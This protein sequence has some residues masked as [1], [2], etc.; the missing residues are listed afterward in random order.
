MVLLKGRQNEYPEFTIVKESKPNRK[1]AID[2]KST[3]RKRTKKGGVE[4]FSFTLGSFRSYLRD[5]EG[6]KSILFPCAEYSEH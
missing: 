2:V 3:Y 4:K 6:K 1:I 5:P